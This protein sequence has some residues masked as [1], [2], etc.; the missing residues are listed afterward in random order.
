[1]PGQNP[2]LTTLFKAGCFDNDNINA[3]NTNLTNVNTAFTNSPGIVGTP[4]NNG[5]LAFGSYTTGGTSN[6]LLATGHAAGT[7]RI[8]VYAVITTTFVTS[9]AIQHNL[10]W[11]DDQGAR[12]QTNALGALTAGTNQ[13]FTTTVRSTGAAALVLNQVGTVANATAGAM[14]L[15]AFVERLV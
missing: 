15:S 11:T 13:I 14:A 4:I 3:L 1:M 12:T 10:G 8:T 9:T 7:Y 5:A 6:T 2:T